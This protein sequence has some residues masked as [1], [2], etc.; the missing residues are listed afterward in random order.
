MAT[1]SKQVYLWVFPKNPETP[2]RDFEYAIRKDKP[3]PKASKLVT[4]ASEEFTDLRTK[5]NT[6]LQIALAGLY[7]IGQPIN[8]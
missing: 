3:E 8:G 4:L 1:K 6:A 5:R 2:D 7:R